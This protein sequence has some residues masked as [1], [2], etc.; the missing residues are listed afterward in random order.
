MSVTSHYVIPQGKKPFHQ[1]TRR[2]T[3][4]FSTLLMEKQQQNPE[5]PSLT[6]VGQKH[7]SFFFGPKVT[8]HSG[9]NDKYHSVLSISASIKGEGKTEE[10]TKLANN[11]IASCGTIG[12]FF[13]L[14]R[15]LSKESGAQEACS[16]FPSHLH[17]PLTAETSIYIH[18]LDPLSPA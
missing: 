2:A 18:C 11:I 16:S 14:D 10:N 6:P 9:V 12:S 1:R 7:L 4:P 17:T 15:H 8:R 13:P 5:N 3:V